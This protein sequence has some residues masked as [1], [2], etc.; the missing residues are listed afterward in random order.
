MHC[1]AHETEIEGK[2]ERERETEITLKVESLTFCLCVIDWN[3][4]FLI[5]TTGCEELVSRQ[6]AS[7]GTIGTGDTIRRAGAKREGEGR[8]T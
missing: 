7:A 2:R 8:S 3:A 1:C 6:A 4:T 5:L